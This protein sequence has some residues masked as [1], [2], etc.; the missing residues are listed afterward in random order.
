MRGIIFGDMQKGD[1]SVS[2]PVF[3][4][5]LDLLLRLI[6][7]EE[8]DI[9]RVALSQVTDQYIKHIS[10]LNERRVEG[11]ADFLVLAAR[12]VLIKSRALLPRPPTLGPAEPD[13]GEELARQL[14]TYR[15]FKWAS[16]MFMER[17]RVG[18][19]T[20]VRL[21]GPARVRPALDLSDVSVRDLAAALSAVL[22]RSIERRTRVSEV[23]GRPRFSVRGRIKVI[24]RSLR[25][26][27]QTSF[28]G[29]LGGGRSRGE[30]VA[31]FLAIL[32]LSRRNM[33]QAVQTE[34]FGDIEIV[35]QGDWR[36]SEVHGMATELD[37]ATADAE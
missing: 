11:L 27:L 2:L 6:E 5:P 10:G 13:P 20:F 9:T 35:R 17:Q 23:V 1:Y 21:V 18:V 36:E 24:A 30:I 19:R 12:L 25:R 31:T 28:F 29:L 33:V 34:T 16:H 32:E 15:R 37:G 7:R 3:N 4:G 22:G 8:L 26:R 14:R